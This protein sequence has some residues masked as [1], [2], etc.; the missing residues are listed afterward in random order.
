VIYSEEWRRNKR[1]DLTGNTDNPSSNKFGLSDTEELKE[2]R[3]IT[4]AD[5]NSSKI[6]GTAESI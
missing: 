2:L 1:K 6:I 3:A 5:S 4:T